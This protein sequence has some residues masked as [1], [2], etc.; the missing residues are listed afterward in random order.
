MK[1]I[2]TLF[3]ASFAFSLN[4]HADDLLVKLA[5]PVSADRMSQYFQSKGLQSEALTENWVRLQGSSSALQSFRNGGVLESSAVLHVQKNYKI[6]LRENPSL[7][8]ALADYL[9]KYPQMKNA[10]FSAAK[11][12]P[13]IPAAPSTTTGADPL[14]NRQWGMKDI[15]VAQAWDIFK[16]DDK[17]IVAVIDTGVDYTHED[18]LPNLWRNPFEI[19]DNQID[20]DN[21]GYV[22]DIIGWDFFSNDNLPYDLAASSL[23]E[24]LNGGNPGHGTH[25]AGNV[26]AR[27]DNGL[28]IA[29]V[30]PN[31]KIMS[32]RFLGDKGGTTADA[33]KSIKYAVDNGAK[34]LSNSWGSEGEDPDDAINNQA[35]RDIITYAAERDVLFIAAAGNGHQGKGYDND[36]D[37]HPAYPAS[38]SHDNIISVAALDVNNNFGSFSNWGSVS[39]DIG[40]PGVK[41]FSTTVGQ[42][43]SDTVIPLL[44]ANW[45]G[46]SMACPHVAGA[47]A[48]YWSRHPHKT[49]QEVKEAILSSAIPIPAAAGKLVTGGKLNV[50]NLMKQ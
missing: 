7:K 14:F 21:N 3:L 37:P 35:L 45:D 6:Q 42:K 9:A 40:A 44:N 49:Y 11:D 36:N 17:V 43:Y 4:V 15:G 19:P 12:N 32:I 47:A 16:G 23:G 5:K 1:T 31:A 28:G 25:C 24:L 22:D 8:Q 29:G 33:I 13:A 39:V 30:A 20:D 18:L 50:E 34:V 27:A 10:A 26:A 38:Y 41:V 48:L 46:T 2:L